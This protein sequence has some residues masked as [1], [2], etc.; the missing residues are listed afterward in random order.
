TLDNGQARGG[1]DFGNY[2]PAVIHGQ[3]FLDRNG[4]G[5]RDPD[6]PG[7]NGVTIRLF[8]LSTGQPVATQ[9]EAVTATAE[10]D[11]QP[12]TDPVIEQGVY[13]VRGVRPGTYLV[14]ESAS[15]QTMPLS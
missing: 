4:N 13:W 5:V 9:Y 6:E 12:G 3:T 15:A 10:L 14:Q 1:L 11:G 2:Q 8:D 7:I